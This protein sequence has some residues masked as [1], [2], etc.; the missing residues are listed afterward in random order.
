MS[1][2]GAARSKPPPALPAA[3]PR[4][5]GRL[6]L[7]TACGGPSPEPSRG[8]PLSRAHP[9]RRRCVARCRYGALT[10]LSKKKTRLQYGDEQFKKW[11]R[12]YDTKPPAVS[13]FSQH[14]PGNDQRYVENIRDVRVSSKET[15]IR[16]LEAGKLV[17][18]RHPPRPR[19]RNR[20]MGGWGGGDLE[21]SCTPCTPLDGVHIALWRPHV[22]CSPNLPRAGPPQAAPLRVAQRLHGSHDPVLGR[23]DRA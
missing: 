3:A 20:V 19:R 22:L 13:S 21:R 14:Y 12:S 17:V 4:P 9:Q 5:G 18:G 16:S 1:A 6:P 7:P 15:L 11:R 8:A 23:H 2:C 10:G